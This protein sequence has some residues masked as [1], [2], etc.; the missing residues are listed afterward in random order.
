MPNLYP[1]TQRMNH[2]MLQQG[3]SHGAS[4]L[5]RGSG[6]SFSELGYCACT[7]LK[8]YYI[9]MDD[10]DPGRAPVRKGCSS[11]GRTGAKVA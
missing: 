11:G 5:F 6:G 2:M 3:W 9:R 8:H 10:Y 4:V 7:L 1:V